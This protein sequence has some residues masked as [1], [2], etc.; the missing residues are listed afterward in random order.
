MPWRGL[1]RPPAELVVKPDGCDCRTLHVS[2]QGFFQYLANKDCPWKYQPLA[3]AM[4]EILTEDECKG[5]FGSP[6]LILG[7]SEYTS[8]RLFFIRILPVRA[9]VCLAPC[10]HGLKDRDKALAEFSKRIFYLRRNFLVNFPVEE[11]V[12]FQFPELL[13][14]RGLRDAVKAA[15]QFTKTLDFVK[16]YIP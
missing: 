10:H 15:H 6:F 8:L 1:S 2:R 13:C 16:G 12:T 9:E 11:T 7:I 14:E 3:D 4:K 5:C